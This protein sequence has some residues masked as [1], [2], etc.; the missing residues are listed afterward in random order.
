MEFKTEV[1]FNNTFEKLKNHQSLKLYKSKIPYL[2]DTYDQTESIHYVA[3]SSSTY[4]MVESVPSHSKPGTCVIQVTGF[5]SH[6]VNCDTIFILFGVY[7]DVLKTKVN[8][9]TPTPCA[10]VEFKNED[11]AERAIRFLGKNGTPCPLYNDIIQISYAPFSVLEEP[12]TLEEGEEFK[13]YLGS[14]LHRFT[15]GSATGRIKNI[16]HVY[17]PN[18][19]LCISN[20]NYNSQSSTIESEF[21]K[22]NLRIENIKFFGHKQKLG[23]KMALVSFPTLNDAVTALVECHDI[24]I[25]DYHININ[26][27]D[28]NANNNNFM[29]M[30]RLPYNVIN[31]NMG[32]PHQ[33]HYS[34]MG[35][36]TPF[37]ASGHALAF[38]PTAGSPQ[39][40]NFVYSPRGRGGNAYRGNI[41]VNRGRGRG[42]YT[43]YNNDNNYQKENTT[44]D[45]NADNTKYQ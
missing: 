36:Y 6:K 21:M 16:D 44:D 30:N 4:T 34:P 7:G 31:R 27:A 12:T 22:Y 20:I 15:K 33:R 39:F 5:T 10:Y 40:Q 13:A 28:N 19:V 43:N 18:R 38:P 25:D 37:A 14:P 8:F 26:F 42:N 32:M 29:M 3:T 11:G 41:M 17:P 9:N 23:T 24:K 1:D 35:T 2:E 45:N